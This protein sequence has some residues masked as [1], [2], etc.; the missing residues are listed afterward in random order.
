MRSSHAS[1]AGYL[2]S[3][4]PERRESI[5]AVRRTIIEN[6]DPQYVETMCYGM[7]GYVVPHS[8]YPPGYHCNPEQ[9]LPFAALGSQK[10]YMAL[11]LMCIYGHEAHQAWFRD[12]W[13]RT[14][15]KLDMGKAC[16]RFKRAADLALD[17]I[18]EA[19]RRVP[20]KKY[21]EA[22]EA[23]LGSRRGRAKPSAKPKA[24]T[25]PKKKPAPRKPVSRKKTGSKRAGRRARA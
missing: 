18:G 5:N 3:L 1:V 20:V 15:K 13:A 2:A 23:L 8:V 25:G 21:V 11:H 22:Y 12:A 17:V 24:G 10:N 14:G 7:I 6:L 19:V 9:P 16:I 4:T